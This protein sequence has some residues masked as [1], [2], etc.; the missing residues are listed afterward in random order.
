[1]MPSIPTPQLLAVGTAVLVFAIACSG[2]DTGGATSGTA[3]TATGGDASTS[4]LPADAP[5]VAGWKTDWS[6]TT[7]DLR[8]LTRG[9]AASDPRDIITPW[10]SHRSRASI[11]LRTGLKIANPWRYW[12]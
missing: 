12:S 6:Q 11:L 1:M 9:I 8:E 3:P 4:E 5:D 10:T 7:I 2:G